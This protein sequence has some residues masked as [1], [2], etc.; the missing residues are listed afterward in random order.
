MTKNF[1]SSKSGPKN[2][3]TPAQK[4]GLSENFSNSI[5]LVADPFA[6]CRF[7]LSPSQPFYCLNQARKSLFMHFI[8]YCYHCVSNLVPMWVEV[9]LVEAFNRPGWKKSEKTPKVKWLSRARART[10]V[11]FLRFSPFVCFRFVLPRIRRKL[12][13]G[14]RKK[15]YIK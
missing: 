3:H 10:V 1:Q 8:H 9:Y 2:T 13:E 15:K 7:S 4:N 6:L 14:K 11:I 12:W 5:S